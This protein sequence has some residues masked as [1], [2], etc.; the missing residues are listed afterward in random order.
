ML[1]LIEM[2]INKYEILNCIFMGLVVPK[3]SNIY[4]ESN[5]LEI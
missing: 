1:N 2:H 5:K 4:S 3:G